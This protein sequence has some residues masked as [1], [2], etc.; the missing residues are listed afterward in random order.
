MVGCILWQVNLL[1]NQLEKKIKIINK[2]LVANNGLPTI[3]VEIMGV[4][5]LN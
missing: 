2:N 5:Q 3:V 4:F 1:A